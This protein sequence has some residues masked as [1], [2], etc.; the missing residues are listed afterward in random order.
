MGYRMDHL[1]EAWHES[2]AVNTSWRRGQAF[3]NVLREYDPRTAEALRVS[4][5][6]PFYDDDNLTAA[7][8]FV[9]ELYN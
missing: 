1:I 7:I 6:N 5:A 2:L 4:T 8:A 9:D 3:Y